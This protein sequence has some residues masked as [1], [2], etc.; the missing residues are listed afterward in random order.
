MKVILQRDLFIRSEKEFLTAGKKYS[1]EFLL[2]DVLDEKTMLKYHEQWANCFVLGAETYSMEFYQSIRPGSAV[3]RYGVG[4]NAVPVKL[5]RQRGIKVAYTP[6][7]LTDSVAEHTFAMLLGMNRN[8]PQLHQSMKEKRW[9]GLTGMELKGKT[10]A[11]LGFGQIGKAVAK[12]AKYGF[13]MRVHAY[14]ILPLPDD[15]VAD[16][17]SNN[18]AE[19]VKEAD[20]VTIHIAVTPKTAGFFN[21]ERIALCKEGVQFVNTSR[22]NLVDEKALFDA[23]LSGKI[24]KAAMDVFVREPY[25]PTE[26]ADFRELDNVLLT[27]HCGSNTKEASERMAMV[28]IQNII[29]YAKGEEMILIPELKQTTQ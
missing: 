6:G 22:G 19:V 3:I 18:Y 20:I 13:G 11:I 27:P 4:Y 2:A 9:Q 29:A 7:T 1:I 23:L 12:I 21:A 24:E 14:D 16:F 8:I 17:F 26:N 15:H 10:I 5:C 28:V 25:I